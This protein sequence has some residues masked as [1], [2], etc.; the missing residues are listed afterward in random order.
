MKIKAKVTRRNVHSFIHTYLFVKRK[1][2][3]G[4]NTLLCHSCSLSQVFS[5][6][7]KKWRVGNLTAPRSSHVATLATHKIKK[8][9]KLF[10]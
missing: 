2:K 9:Q 1:V 3:K 7:S 8:K 4:I 10:Y 5:F 6:M